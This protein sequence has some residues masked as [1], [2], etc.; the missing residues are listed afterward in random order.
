M[1]RLALLAAACALAGPAGCGR[2][3][4]SVPLGVRVLRDGAP[5]LATARP[6]NARPMDVTCTLQT[7]NAARAGDC[8]VTLRAAQAVYGP[9][10][11]LA[12]G[13]YQVEFDVQTTGACPGV[14]SVTFDVVTNANHFEPLGRRNE[15][16][17]G[18]GAHVLDIKVDDV[19]AD[20]APFEFRTQT[21]PEPGACM[22]L[23]KVLVK[24]L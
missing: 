7:Q 12:A 10:A 19:L 6:R 21:G 18:S 22:I 8:S 15:A 4:A 13:R 1:S 24:P 11:P 20:S 2:Q 14:G 23:K 17:T 16:V 5:T 9:Y 3:T